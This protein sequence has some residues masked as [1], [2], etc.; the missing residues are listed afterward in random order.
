MP[1]VANN[2]TIWVELQSVTCYSC[3]VAFGMSKGFYADRLRDQRNFFCPNGHGQHFIGKTEAD[4]L[5]EQLAAK[6]A[7]IIR[8]REATARARDD[9]LRQDR[10]R[11]YVKGQL[12][13]AKKHVAAGVCPV[14]ECHRHFANL[15][16]HMTTK[17][18]DYV[19]QDI[20]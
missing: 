17:H 13:K 4:R 11:R 14:G 8:E 7:E 16:R 19:G 2:I 3:G 15:G 9:A 20:G 12:T 6:E 18:P 5:R 1:Q 10:R